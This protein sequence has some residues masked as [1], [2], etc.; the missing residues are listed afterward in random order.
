MKWM[1]FLFPCLLLGQIYPFP[2]V[3]YA[4]STSGSTFTYVN[5]AGNNCGA[6]ATTCAATISPTFGHAIIVDFVIGA[7]VLTPTFTVTDS[8]SS[9]YTLAKNATGTLGDHS[10]VAEYYNCSIPGGITSIG[11]TSIVGSTAGTEVIVREYS[12]TGTCAIDQTSSVTT[13]TGTTITS[14]SLTTTAT[15]ELI[16]A[17][18]WQSN[19][20]QAVTG[21]GSYVS[22]IDIGNGSMTISGM[23]RMVT[24]TGSFAPTGTVGASATWVA[25]TVSYQ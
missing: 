12:Y 17:P 10:I 11:L 13:G 24:A 4:H 15:H 9:T 16:S 1:I 22:R 6:G 18:F 7:A 5:S 21:T 3:P 20:S 2:T 8:G 23:D 25:F 14:G 19:Q